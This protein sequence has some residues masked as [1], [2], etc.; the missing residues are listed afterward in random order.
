MKLTPD[1]LKTVEPQKGKRLEFRDDEEKGLIFRVTE[2]GHKSWSVRYVAATTGEQRRETYQYPEIG[3]ARARELCRKLKGASSEGRDV[4]G[5]RK[6]ARAETER[7]KKDRL[8]LISEA[9]FSA[10]KIGAQR[11]GSRV[12]P[13]SETTIAEE[14]R[15][16]NSDL[17]PKFGQ[18]PVTSLTNREIGDYISALTAT[19]ASKGR[20][21][22]R[23][24]RQILNYA[25]LRG[26]IEH[27]PADRVA[28]V[29]IGER[30]RY[31]S[32]P[33]IK[34]MWDLLANIEEREKIQIGDEMALLLQFLIL[35]PLRVKEVSG[36]RWDEIDRGKKV[37]TVPGERMKG[38]RTHVAP[39]SPEAFTV[40]ER[41]KQI[42]GDKTYIFASPVTG[43]PLARQSIAHAFSRASKH[44]KFVERATPH[45]LRRTMTTALTSKDRL[46]VGRD[47]ARLLLAHADNGDTISRHYDQHDYLSEKADAAARWG[48]L[49]MEIVSDIHENRKPS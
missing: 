19:A 48:R 25:I 36:A 47:I 15:V 46:G 37:W 1:F 11:V 28:V 18:R 5:E 43:L 22:H 9:Y 38:R 42:V 14:T 16:W 34:A 23:L 41:A 31:L 10:S 44:L 7:A 35:C 4:A 39:L 17:K 32:D 6:K 13:K 26:V 12:K 49:V 29:A 2:S 45:D 20:N 27:N 33:E 30:K 40:L 24:L 8:E 3:L 21:A